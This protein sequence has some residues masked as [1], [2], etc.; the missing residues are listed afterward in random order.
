M[1]IQF[2]Y[3]FSFECLLDISALS[4]FLAN[5]LQKLERIVHWSK[6]PRLKPK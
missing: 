3:T 2:E 1:N 6:L 4:K 5:N